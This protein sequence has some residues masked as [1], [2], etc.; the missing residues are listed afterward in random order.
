[1]YPEDRA[2][3]VLLRTLMADGTLTLGQKEA[4]AKL[5]TADS[6]KLRGLECREQYCVQC[7]KQG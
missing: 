7:G 4:S 1:M 5:I 2:R 3:R 6:V